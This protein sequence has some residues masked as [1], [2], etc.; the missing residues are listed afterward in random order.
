MV[1]RKCKSQFQAS[2]SFVL[3]LPWLSLIQFV[4]NMIVTNL[5]MIVTN[6]RMIVTNLSMIKTNPSLIVTNLI[7][8]VVVTIVK[9]LPVDS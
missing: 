7:P 1:W 3:P 4:P 8:F 6:L 9:H 2:S 5:S